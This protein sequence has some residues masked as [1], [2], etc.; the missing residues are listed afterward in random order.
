MKVIVNAH[1]I[2]LDKTTIVNKGE[3][4]IQECEFEFSSEYNGLV[5]VEIG[6]AH[7]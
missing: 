5:E 3:Y 7:V 4:N 6:R 2:Q 1:T